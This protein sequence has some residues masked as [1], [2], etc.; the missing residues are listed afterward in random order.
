MWVLEL[1]DPSATRE[2]DGAV[3]RSRQR[4]E[5]RVRWREDYT[6]VASTVIVIAFNAR[7]TGQPSLAACAIF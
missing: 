1:R 4:H 2:I 6:S 5:H 3:T 7:E